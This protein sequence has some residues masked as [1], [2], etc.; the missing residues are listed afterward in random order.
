MGLLSMKRRLSALMESTEV[1]VIVALFF[2]F[3]SLFS[4]SVFIARDLGCKFLECV[5]GDS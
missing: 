1:F 5:N 2:F 3:P 4:F